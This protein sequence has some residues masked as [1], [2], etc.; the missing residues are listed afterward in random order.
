MSMTKTRRLELRTDETTDQLI[1]EAAELLHVSKTAFVTDAARQA[2]ERV[3]ARADTTLMAPEIFDAMM[4]SLDV[5]DESSEL[6]TLSKLPRLI[7][8]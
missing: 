5:A 7:R 6:E 4:A 8:R 3:V 1:S 2:A